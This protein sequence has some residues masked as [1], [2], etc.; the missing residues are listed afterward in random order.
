MG[1][2]KHKYCFSSGD[3]YLFIFIGLHNGIST[4]GNLRL[5]ESSSGIY[6]DFQNISNTHLCSYNTIQRTSIPNDSD[7]LGVVT[8]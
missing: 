6:K 4:C 8:G 5:S 2:V 1:E 3:F 7:D